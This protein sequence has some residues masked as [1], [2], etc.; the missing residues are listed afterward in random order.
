MALYFYFQ[1]DPTS[2]ASPQQQPYNLNGKQM[3]EAGI[4]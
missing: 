1:H 4:F 2:G 3:I